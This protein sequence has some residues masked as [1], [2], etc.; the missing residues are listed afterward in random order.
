[1][2]SMLLP[3]ILSS[4]VSVI[5]NTLYYYIILKPQ[6]SIEALQGQVQKQVEKETERLN[7]RV[8]EGFKANSD[9]RRSMYE[10][11][12]ENLVARR[13][14]SAQHAHGS[15]VTAGFERRLSG[16]HAE[17]SEIG[18]Q[19]AGTNSVL[20]LIAEHLHISLPE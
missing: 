14:C 1:M 15:D 12:R 13:E 17:L 7:R 2:M 6:T 11:M 10:H 5:F 18:K 8:E 19:M 20:K 16:M 4:V 3:V 9:A